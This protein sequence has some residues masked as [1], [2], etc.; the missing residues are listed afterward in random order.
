MHRYQPTSL[1]EQMKAANPPANNDD[2][3]EAR[4]SMLP[5]PHGP[6]SV[7]G[8][9]PGHVFWWHV[10]DDDFLL[11]LCHDCSSPLRDFQ[12]GQWHPLPQ[13]ADLLKAWDNRMPSHGYE[14][15]ELDGWAEID[16]GA[17]IEAIAG[18]ARRRR[19]QITHA[20][21]MERNRDSG[22]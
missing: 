22:S 4:R 7:C 12:N 11:L 15:S 18:H 1:E 5:S 19:L 13:I 17:S 6:C 14:W 16:G 9:D 20:F 21:E 3:D 8:V 10:G 2:R